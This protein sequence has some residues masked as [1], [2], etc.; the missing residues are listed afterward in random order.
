M[1]KQ[2]VNNQL[3][4]ARVGG[5]TGSRCSGSCFVPMPRVQGKSSA[6]SPACCTPAAA[7]RAEFSGKRTTLELY[8]WLNQPDQNSGAQVLQVV[9]PAAW[10]VTQAQASPAPNFR[11]QAPRMQRTLWRGGETPLS[12]RRIAAAN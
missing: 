8:T 2:S 11:F 7:L 10:L 5:S 1:P 12:S 9:R 4:G 3:E 6:L